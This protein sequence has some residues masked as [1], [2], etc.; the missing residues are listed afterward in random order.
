MLLD[1]VRLDPASIETARGNVAAA[2]LDD[3]VYASVQDASD[4]HLD[5]LYDLVTIFE[6]VADPLSLRPLA[7]GERVVD[8]GSGAGFD[9]FV[10]AAWVGAAGRVVGVDM[11]PEIVDKARAT[12]QH[13]GLANVELRAGLIEDVTVDD[14]WADVVMS[15]GVLNLVA[16]KPRA[17]REI[18]RVLRP[19]GAL[20]FADIAVG[21]A[22]PDE[23]ACNI[24]LW[25]D[26]IAGGGLR[27]SVPGCHRWPR[28]H[29]PRPSGR[30]CL[31]ERLR[32]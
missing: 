29:R 17:M 1:V 30:E 4:G 15:N 11:T 9:C 2:G 6:G 13:L 20:A 27:V 26:C 28:R 8:L 14:G 22:V 31:G 12:A 32:G 19:G 10:A 21:R 24:E 16:D 25:T 5:G 23:A 7:P 3:R 18:F